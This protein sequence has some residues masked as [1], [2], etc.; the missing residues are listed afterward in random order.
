MMKEQ[1]VSKYRLHDSTSILVFLHGE[2]EDKSMIAPDWLIESN[3][4]SE[5]ER[6]FVAL[7]NSRHACGYPLP[8]RKRSIVWFE[9]NLQDLVVSFTAFE[10]C[11]SKCSNSRTEGDVLQETCRTVA[12]ELSDPQQHAAFETKNF[13][14]QFE[15]SWA[16][17]EFCPHA[18]DAWSH[19]HKSQD[20]PLFERWSR[21][22]RDI[23][24]WYSVF[25]RNDQTPRT[26]AITLQHSFVCMKR[27]HIEFQ[28]R[29]VSK[30]R[31]H[32][33][34]LDLVAFPH[35]LVLD[36]PSEQVSKK[37]VS[38]KSPHH[39]RSPQ[40]QYEQDPNRV[41]YP[42]MLSF[43]LMV[44]LST[45]VLCQEARLRWQW[46]PL[47]IR[48]WRAF[49]IQEMPV[50][51]EQ[52]D[53][54]FHFSIF[55]PCLMMWDTTE[56]PIDAGWQ[57]WTS[58]FCVFILRVEEITSLLPRLRVRFRPGHRR[59]LSESTKGRKAQFQTWS[60]KTSWTEAQRTD[61][62]HDTLYALLEKM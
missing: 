51:Y 44:R 19:Q 24:E 60:T 46:N 15:R 55:L 16:L 47:R 34:Q 35:H 8:S 31:F 5:S 56:P 54:C 39:D 40:T 50:T 6:C 20:S 45:H 33:S 27:P 3:T 37:W 2:L 28:T 58:L 48:S 61:R 11:L 52:H 25:E 1:D 26:Q 10:I 17:P 29:T 9:V 59:I 38:R 62:L 14:N 53:T 41:L 42:K 23:R 18:V 43:S 22:V 21:N 32:S 30:E 4:V 36:F 7:L 12:S 49:E 57:N 13:L